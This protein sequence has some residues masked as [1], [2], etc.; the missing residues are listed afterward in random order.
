MQKALV[1]LLVILSVSGCQSLSVQDKSLAREIKVKQLL[2]KGERLYRDGVIGEAQELFEEVLEISPDEEQALYR[3]GNIFFIKNDLE[4]SAAFFE[5]SLAVNPDNPKAHYNLGT[6]HLMRAEK[7]MKMFVE[8]VPEE[9]DV[10]KVRRLLSDLAEYAYG[11]SQQ[12]EVAAEGP[13]VD[14]TVILI[15]KR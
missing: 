15:E 8:S 14:E 4:K 9:V 2:A 10:S 3:L 1:A 5:A 11:S 12:E 7:H 6:L 13:T